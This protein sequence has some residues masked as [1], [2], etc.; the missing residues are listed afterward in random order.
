MKRTL[1]ALALAAVLPMS[2]QAG[3]L[4]YS[5]VQGGYS[6]TSDGS[7][8][9]DGFGLKGSV[10]FNDSFYGF[11]SYDSGSKNNVDLDQA[12]IGA[13]WHSSGDTQWF[14]EASYVND[15]VDYGGPSFDED[16]YAVAGGV[17]AA[18]SDKVELNAKVNYTDVGTFGDGFGAGVGGLFSINDT[19]GIYASYDYS[20]RG[21]FDLDTWAVGVRAS[22]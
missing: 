10:A 4:S 14:V 8:D 3:E 13:G 18:V 7:I 12:T 21:S 19:W 1:F 15:S 6:T 11:A 20:D 22:F 5:Y 16:G 9:L 17:R 2:A